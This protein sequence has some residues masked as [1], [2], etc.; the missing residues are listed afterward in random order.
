MLFADLNDENFIMYAMKYYENP[1][2][3]SVEEF[4]DDLSHIKYLK[5]LFRRYKQSKDL[6]ALRLRLVINH[7]IILYNVFTSDTAT[8]ILFFKIEKDLWPILKTFLIF[9]DRMP[10]Y[11]KG[12]NGKD[13]ISTDINVDLKIAAELRRT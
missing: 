13:V 12:V 3:K 9:L 5:R 1:Q 2:C 6:E 8:R 4:Y 7:L 11:I 10:D